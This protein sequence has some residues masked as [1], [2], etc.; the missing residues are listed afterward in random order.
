L[1]VESSGDKLFL[2]R[3]DG[4]VPLQPAGA[5]GV[6]VV[7]DGGNSHFPLVFGRVATA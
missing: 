3:D 6:F 7:A 2:A 5:P 4:K 1:E